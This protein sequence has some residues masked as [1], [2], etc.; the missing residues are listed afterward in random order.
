MPIFTKFPK[1]RWILQGWGFCWGQFLNP[2]INFPVLCIYCWICVF[3]S[4]CSRFIWAH[5]IWLKSDPRSAPCVVTKHQGTC[6]GSDF[7]QI[8]SQFFFFK[9]II[10]G[11]WKL[12]EGKLL[13][14]H[15]CVLSDHI[16]NMDPI[17]YAYN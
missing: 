1:N 17:F 14:V 6:R 15:V 2:E 7:N 13:Y 8:V 5:S 4:M 10:N 9:P 11:N 3:L 12:I 16:K